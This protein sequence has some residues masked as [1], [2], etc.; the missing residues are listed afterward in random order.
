MKDGMI[1][2]RADVYAEE[3]PGTSDSVIM[4]SDSP[5]PL[6]TSIPLVDYDVPDEARSGKV[7]PTTPTIPVT[8]KLL[9]NDTTDTET[10][11]NAV[12]IAQ[13]VLPVPEPRPKIER[14]G[15]DSETKK[16]VT[17]PDDD[18]CVV[19]CIYFTQQCCE[20]MIL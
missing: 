9:N 16:S 20:C 3:M 1:T 17:Q 11:E 19:D 7:T 4:S 13:T 10:I 6:Q 2:T 15:I 14:N 8:T 12:P 18:S 5:S